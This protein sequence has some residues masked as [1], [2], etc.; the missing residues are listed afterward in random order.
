MLSLQQS[1]SAPASVAW[2]L[3]LDRVQQPEQY[4]D[5]IEAVEMLS[6][7]GHTHIR[8]LE[9]ANGA[10][11]ERIV[12]EPAALKITHY[13]VKHPFFKG[14]TVYSILAEDDDNCR[15]DLEQDWEAKKPEFDFAGREAALKTILRELAA[16][17]EA[18]ED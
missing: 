6:Q 3:L 1:V 10:V 4:I 2:E 18:E 17:I 16:Y 5:G 11:T 8:K 13:L 15:L 12:L 14:Q 7:E 9:T